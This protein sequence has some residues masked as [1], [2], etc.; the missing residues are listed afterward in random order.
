M[1]WNPQVRMTPVFKSDQVITMS[2]LLEGEKEEFFCSLVYVE[3]IVEKR[4]VMKRY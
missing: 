4:K 1:V 2:V 3:N